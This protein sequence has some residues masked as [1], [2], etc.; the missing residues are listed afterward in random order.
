MNFKILKC[1]TKVQQNMEK[2]K[3]FEYFL[4]GLYMVHYI[5]YTLYPEVEKDRESSSYLYLHRGGCR[6]ATASN[7]DIV[8]L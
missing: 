2:I 7:R 5:W 4:D 6:R 1:A 3:R 8:H